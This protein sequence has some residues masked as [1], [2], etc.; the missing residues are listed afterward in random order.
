MRLVSMPWARAWLAVGLVFAGVAT[1]GASSASASGVACADCSGS[2][3]G[4]W[5]AQTQYVTPEGTITDGMSLMW[6]ETLTTP[7]GGNGASGVWSL[8]SAQGTVTRMDSGDSSNDCSA[9]LLPNLALAGDIAQFGPQ[10]SEGAS[11]IVVNAYP[12]TY[13]SGDPT[14]T[15]EPLVS[16]DDTD[17]G[18]Y[19]TDELAY[20]SGFWTSFT[21]GSCHYAGISAEAMS[22]P[23]GTKQTI[24]DNCDVQGS[25]SF[26]RTGTATLTSQLTISGPG[27]CAL[28]AAAASPLVVAIQP[29]PLT[30]GPLTDR[31]VVTTSPVVGAVAAA[32]GGLEMRSGMLASP[33]GVAAAGAACGVGIVP[34]PTA[35]TVLQREVL[36]AELPPGASA[37]SYTFEI[38][39]VTG[40]TWKVLGTTGAPSYAFRA[41]VAGNFDVRVIA[42][43]QGNKLTSA[44]ARLVVAFPSYDEIA[45]DTTV[46]TFTKKA[47]KLT[48]R[49][50]N[51][52]SRR[53]VGF[54]I[55]VD[56]C[57]SGGYGQTKTVIPS[58]PTTND[59]VAG[60]ILGSRPA[61]QPSNPPATGCAKYFIADF[62]T[63]TPTWYRK[64]KLVRPIGPSPEDQSTD[65]KDMVPGLVYDYCP[66]PPAK[67]AGNAVDGCVI[68]RASSYVPFGYPLNKPAGL[69]PAGLTRR[70]TPP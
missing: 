6:T 66:D 8:A 34:T 10:V 42:V 48:L 22:F 28:A 11:A 41:N 17:P 39:R 53:E 54:W 56:T 21:G 63:H 37:S 4:S 14:Q 5:S 25:D 16:S 15:S 7:T 58:A 70:P 27:S 45:A 13:W 18:C 33:V 51:P 65:Q 47:W 61:D 52:K 31:A 32:S 67:K 2:Y 35:L 29:N 12:P 20:D 57:K 43:S 46:Q 69:Y 9:S 50:A 26:G 49:L 19:F 60:V 36:K 40:K 55:W 59:A 38:K 44:P 62:H 3:T 24:A 23:I 30:S 68:T 1:L 64:G